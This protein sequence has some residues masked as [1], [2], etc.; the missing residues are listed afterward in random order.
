MTGDPNFEK[1]QAVTANISELEDG[2]LSDGELGESAS[3]V[4]KTSRHSIKCDNG[5]PSKSV[6]NGGNS[7][8]SFN[9]VLKV[10]HEKGI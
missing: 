5:S 9:R 7:E 3:A 2:E 1:S 6:K 8:K 10:N 4:P